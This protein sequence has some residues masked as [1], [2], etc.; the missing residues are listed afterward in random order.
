MTIRSSQ[1]SLVSSYGDAQSN[2]LVHSML[3]AAKLVPKANE[4]TSGGSAIWPAA[5]ASHSVSMPATRTCHTAA[6]EDLAFRAL[7]AFV[8]MK[9]L[10]G[11]TRN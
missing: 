4:S 9:D 10:A 5:L 7:V 3:P 1:P 8:L 6:G 2:E 11:A